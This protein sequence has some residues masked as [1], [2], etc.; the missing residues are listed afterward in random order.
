[1]NIINQILG[2]GIFF[3]EMIPRHPRL[4]PENGCRLTRQDLGQRVSLGCVS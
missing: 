3:G 1:M 4:R 2:K